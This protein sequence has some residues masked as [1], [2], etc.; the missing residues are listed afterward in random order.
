[1][2]PGLQYIDFYWQVMPT[3]YPH[4]VAPHWLDH[5]V[6]GAPVS[7]MALVFWSRMKAHA[8]LPVGD[9]RFEQG[10]AVPER[11]KE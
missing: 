2:D 3:F 11:V 8:L 4:G 9:P 1:M 7:A 10:L 5:R 6:P